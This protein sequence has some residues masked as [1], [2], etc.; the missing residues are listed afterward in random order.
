MPQWNKPDLLPSVVPLPEW[1]WLES[2]E[3][4]TG[5]CDALRER[6]SRGGG[7]RMWHGGDEVQEVTLVAPPGASRYVPLAESREL[8]GA[9]LAGE[10]ARL[11][12][13][14]RWNLFVGVMFMSSFLFRLA[15]KSHSPSFIFLLLLPQVALYV[16]TKLKLDRLLEQPDR[17]LLEHA[18]TKRYR[19][20]LDARGG[21]RCLTCV[22]A[23]IWVIVYAFQFLMPPAG[24]VFGGPPWFATALVKF[25]VVDEPWRLLT[26]TVMHGS[27]PH[28][29]FNVVGMLSLGMIVERGVNRH[30][31]APVWLAGAIAGS[32][33]S[34]AMLPA[35]S[36]G[37][38]G[39]IMAVFAFLLVMAKR[40]PSEL[41]P[42]FYTSLRISAGVIILM[43]I[44][45]WEI[46]DNAAHAGGAVA[47]ALIAWWVFRAD[48]GESPL[49]DSRG[50]V[51][52]NWI[53]LAIIGAVALFTAAKLVVP[54]TL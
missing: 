17:Y 53:A 54:N 8:A 30:L 27:I 35:T 5:T 52:S 33:A 1:S 20:W 49:P 6:L 23:T 47:G 25:V 38:S 37:A 24:N 39:G 34:W 18:T 4:R 48:Q 40:R 41:P 10:E 7:R 51:V 31:V 45:A 19:Y 14:L 42:G 29:L 43:G 12:Q 9:V 36:V 28:L 2:G 21:F 11:R 3:R 44:F 32:L 46:I 26:A 22:L 16:E 15:M 50:L 13:A